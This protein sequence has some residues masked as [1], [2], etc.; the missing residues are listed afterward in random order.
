MGIRQIMLLHKCLNF[1]RFLPVLI[2][3]LIAPDVQIAVRENGGEFTN[4]GIDK[5]IGRIVGRVE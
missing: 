3:N 1:C 2:V 5:F 4:Q